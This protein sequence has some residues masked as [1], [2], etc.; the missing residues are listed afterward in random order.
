MDYK[1]ITA[2]NESAA[3]I[4]ALHTTLVPKRLYQI[5]DQFFIKNASCADIGC[6]IGRDTHWLSQ[7]GY[8][9]IGIDAAEGMLQQARAHYP[10]NQFINDRLPCLTTISD[11]RFSN[12]LC[13]A[14][15][16]HLPA[17]QISLSIANL[18]RVMISCGVIVLSFR[19]TQAVDH[20]EN[21]KLYTPITH[22]GMIATFAT[23]GASL[24]HHES[25]YEIGREF[26]WHNLVF[27]K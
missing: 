11:A 3:A 5:V 17:Q 16:M 27:K 9:V 4:A 21:D 18:L 23:Y 15:I 1:T 24:L 20:R 14:V 7:K 19:G 12:V 13:S 26:E 10:M 25:D 2:Y 8:E 22:E 6:G